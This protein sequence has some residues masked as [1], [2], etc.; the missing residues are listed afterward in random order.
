M[1]IQQPRK[2][3]ITGNMGYVGPVLER[4][5]RHVFPGTSLL[6]LDTGY[7]GNCINS[8]EFLPEVL[9]DLQHFRDVRDID[10]GVLAGVD[11]VLHLAGI[12]NDPI[13][14]RFEDATSEINHRASISLAQ[15]AK[16]AGV[17]SFVFASSCSMYGSADD[18]AKAEN[19]SLNPLTA[20]A[21]SK[22][23][24]ERDLKPL[25]S[26][27]FV[28]TCLRFATA[29]G[30]SDRLRLDLV[31]NDFVAAALS[32]G[33]IQILSDGT[34]WRPLINVKDMARA[35]EWATLRR[36]DTSGAF[37]AVNVGS[38]EWNY[39]VKDL[40]EAVAD[41]IPK[42]A[43]SINQDAAPDKRS[44]RVNFDLYRRLASEHQ[45]K[46]DLYSTIQELASGL[47]QIGFSDQ[48]FRR[49]SYMRLNVLT[50]LRAKQLLDEQL[51][52]AMP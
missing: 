39:Q 26:S 28:V 4:H 17:R 43:I 52:W 40:A 7:F 44:Y 51:R 5:L 37:L 13:G 29:C 45:P 48:D 12:S 42:T 24:T 34:P 32:A 50:E 3:L 9:L 25:A 35:L 33:R 10:P 38:S 20:Y 22:A 11:A 15:K 8:P 31:L 47:E 27:Q 1:E 41:V 49:S 6:G 16:E 14:N 2:I 36:E 46:Y 21:R 19:S 18:S 30:M 23:Y